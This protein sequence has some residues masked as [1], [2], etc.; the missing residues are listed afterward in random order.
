MPV[1]P[2]DTLLLGSDAAGQRRGPP[3]PERLAR[4]AAF[5]VILANGGPNGMWEAAMP[6]SASG[7][8]GMDGVPFGLSGFKTPR[9]SSRGPQS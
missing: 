3:S 1:C 2:V 5:G 7:V 8:C 9:C 4:G 6:L